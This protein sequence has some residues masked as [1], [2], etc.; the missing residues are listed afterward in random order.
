MS[1]GETSVAQMIAQCKEGVFVNRVSDVDMIDVYTCL[2]TGATHGGCFLVK[3]GKISKPIKNFRFLESPFFFL[4]RIEALGQPERAAFG[5]TPT[6]TYGDGDGTWPR[7]PVI[8]PPMMVRDFNFS[9][10]CD[11]V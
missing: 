4:N 6:A 10:L 1:G 9:A 5:Y 11:A 3:D 8:V 7:Q 2:L